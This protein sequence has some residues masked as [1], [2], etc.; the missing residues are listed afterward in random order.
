VWCKSK[1][2]QEKI[3]SFE[4]SGKKIISNLRNY[5]DTKSKEKT[6]CDGGSSTGAASASANTATL[7]PGF[8]AASF[9]TG[10]T[11]VSAG[12][13][14]D[15]SVAGAVSTDATLAPTSATAQVPI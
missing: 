8:S 13:E 15:P 5:D 11:F 14:A 4:L 2:G 10:T 6:L 9:P 1:K 7:S 12:V 3:R